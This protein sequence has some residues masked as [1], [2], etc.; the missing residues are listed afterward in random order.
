MKNGLNK[1]YFV[2]VVTI[3]V[4]VILAILAIIF[5]AILE[6]ND[7]YVGLGIPLVIIV[8]SILIGID[9]YFA[10][11]YYYYWKNPELRVDRNGKG[12]DEP[13]EN[14]VQVARPRRNN[15]I[16]NI[17]VLY[18][19]QRQREEVYQGAP[20][21]IPPGTECDQEFAQVPAAQQNKGF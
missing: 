12:P 8:S 1:T 2:R 21:A 20:I 19:P 7:L 10:L 9:I 6:D 16:P 5:I 11:M 13:A 15:S 17:Q 3:C 14:N 18:I 4:S